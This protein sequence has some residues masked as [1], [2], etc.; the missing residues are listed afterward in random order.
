MLKFK[1]IP[2]EFFYLASHG[3]VDISKQNGEKITLKWKTIPDNVSIIFTS[4]MGYSVSE[5]INNGSKKFYSSIKQLLEFKENPGKFTLNTKHDGLKQFI[6]LP[7][8]TRYIDQD[9]D[10]IPY[11][12]RKNWEKSELGLYKL[13]MNENNRDL[14]TCFH[15]YNKNAKDNIYTIS[16]FIS[17]FMSTKSHKHRCNEI[18]KNGGILFVDTCRLIWTESKG[19]NEKLR[20]CRT[21]GTINKSIMKIPYNGTKQLYQNGRQVN[22]NRFSNLKKYKELEIA[23]S[24]KFKR[25]FLKKNLK[26]DIRTI[27]T[28]ATKRN[29]NENDNLQYT[30][31]SVKVIEKHVKKYLNK[32]KFINQ[33]RNIKL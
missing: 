26:Q 16:S 11:S 10:I 8:G 25:L 17:S 20:Y 19:Q 30:K 6:I 7:P 21:S 14:L 33:I 3:C 12:S 32:K 18:S 4:P 27:M 1:K 28:T 31:Q 2:D 5:K 13:P 23:R 22:I 29:I 24:D 15:K 9:I